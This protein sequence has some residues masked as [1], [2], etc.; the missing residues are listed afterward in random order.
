MQALYQNWEIR[1]GPYGISS[2]QVR[3]TEEGRGGMYRI[4]QG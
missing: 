3:V 1:G 4:V 2:N